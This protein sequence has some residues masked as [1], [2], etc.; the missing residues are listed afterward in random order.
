MRALRALSGGLTPLILIAA[1]AAIG[2]WLLRMSIVRRAEAEQTAE[3]MVIAATRVKRGDFEVGVKALG[4]LEAVSSKPV[5]ARV[6]GQIVHLAPDGVEVKEG[7]VIAELDVPRM[8][9]RLRDQEM[10]YQQALDDLDTKRRE[11]AAEVEKARVGLDKA[12]TEL[13]QYQRQQESELA[14]KRSQKAQDTEDLDLRRKRFK[15]ESSLAEEGLVPRRDIEIRTAELTA[16]EFGVQRETK[17]LE[18]A[19]ARKSAEE[20]DKQAAVTKAEADL[21]RAESKQADETRDATTTLKIRETQLA[22]VRDEFEKSVIRAPA[23]GIVVLLD[24]WQGGGM[25]RRPVQP[26]DRVWEGRSIATIPDLDKM[27]V[28][29]EL[30]QDQARLVKRKQEAEITVEALPGQTFPGEVTEVSQTARESSFP[31]TGMP[32]G[33]RTFQAYA[34]VKDRKGAPL[35][36]GMTAHVWIIVDRVQ[37]AVSVPLECVF[38]RD[39]RHIAY[40]RRG[41]E[42]QAVE[43]D[44][45]ARND[46]AVVITKG[47]KGGEEVALRDLREPGAEASDPGANTGSSPLLR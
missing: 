17:E 35:R 26:G 24:Q 9:R 2:A 34:E 20:L 10:Q 38:E 15:R 33:E 42:F 13:V 30:T 45:G 21:A 32:R 18:L 28:V 7:E 8:M 6:S 40:V 43:V 12:K 22:R 29:L 25:A 4:K 11:L 36:P 1:I 16:K 47:L 39:G 23:D 44:L 14:E 27:R 31:G 19:E 3:Q 41:R 46:D 37:K 5:V